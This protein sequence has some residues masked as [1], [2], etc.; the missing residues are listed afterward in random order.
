MAK[1]IAVPLSAG[2][3]III[4]DKDYFCFEGH[5]AA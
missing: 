5:N 1:F 4:Y 2:E 3:Q